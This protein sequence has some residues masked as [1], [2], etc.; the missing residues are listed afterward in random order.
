MV[1]DTSILNTILDM[2]DTNA[3]ADWSANDPAHEFREV[4]RFIR[5]ERTSEFMLNNGTTEQKEAYEALKDKWPN[6]GVPFKEILSDTWLVWVSGPE[7]GSM[8]LGIATDGS[9]HS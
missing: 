8:M 6:V 1:S 4:G 5:D 2:V 7:A 3:A 9:T